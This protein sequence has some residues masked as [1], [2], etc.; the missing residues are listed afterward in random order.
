MGILFRIRRAAILF[1]S[2]SITVVVNDGVCSN[3][4][5]GHARRGKELTGWD[6]SVKTS[7]VWSPESPGSECKNPLKSFTNLAERR[8]S[9]GPKAGGAPV[10]DYNACYS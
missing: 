7:R 6:V 9:G 8:R 3:P 1:R 10:K 5:A 2:L 4:V